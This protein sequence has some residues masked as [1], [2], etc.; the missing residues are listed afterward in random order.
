MAAAY[1]LKIAFDIGTA[2]FG[3][4]IFDPVENTHTL[5]KLDLL[6]DR[7]KTGTWRRIDMEERL[8]QRFV[9]DVASTMHEYLARA[10]EVAAEAEKGRTICV[11]AHALLAFIKGRYPHIETFKLSAR[12]WRAC[13]TKLL[14]ARLGNFAKY[15]ARKTASKT[16]LRSLLHKRD[17]QRYEKNFTC[18]EAV[19]VKGKGKGAFKFKPQRVLRID[20][21]E[22]M[23]MTLTMHYFPKHLRKLRDRRPSYKDYKP[24]EVRPVRAM[25]VQLKRDLA[26]A[27][28]ASTRQSTLE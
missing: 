5:V 12:V 13:T 4:N 11:F 17:W 10:C 16:V 19:K 24:Y 2:N 27:P 20:P 23:F 22:S 1:P 7:D 3:A 26:P 15:D 8:V 6:L 25:R 9:E 18:T 21:G 14:K 28:A